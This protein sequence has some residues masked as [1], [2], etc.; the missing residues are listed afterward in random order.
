MNVILR[1]FRPKKTYSI[2]PTMGIKSNTIT[3][4]IVFAG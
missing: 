1:V 3:Q 2:I 4:A